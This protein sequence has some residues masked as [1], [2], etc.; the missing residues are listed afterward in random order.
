MC[1]ACRKPKDTLTTI[2]FFT[3]VCVHNIPSQRGY[4]LEPAPA[5][6]KHSENSRDFSSASALHNIFEY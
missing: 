5:A 3:F 6:P 1:K 4:F 2:A